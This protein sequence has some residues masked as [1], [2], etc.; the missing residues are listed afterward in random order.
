M[1][2]IRHRRFEDLP[3][4]VYTG[5][6]HK[7]ESLVREFDE[8]FDRV[9]AALSEVYLVDTEGGCGIE[10]APISMSRY[11]DIC[12]QHTIVV[13]RGAW[14][15]DVVRILHE[16][17]KSL[18]QGWTFAIDVAGCPSG[19]AHI[20]VESDGTVHGWSDYAARAA[21]SVFGFDRL[22]GLFRNIDFAVTSFMDDLR[23]RRSIRK[24]LSKPFRI[25][26]HIQPNNE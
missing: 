18:P 14:H 17:L 6:E 24:A 19:Q 25:E 8:A 11:V 3:S 7:D 5:E 4:P 23:R 12:R 21:L 26:D 20:V 16:Q 15:P 9:A 10:G 13:E 22:T 1:K 2:Y